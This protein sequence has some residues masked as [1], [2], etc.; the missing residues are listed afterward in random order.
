MSHFSPIKDPRVM[1]PTP[2]IFIKK[3]PRARD[4]APGVFVVKK[5]LY[6]WHGLSD[7]V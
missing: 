5:L 4:T 1:D 3:E 2:G 7:C 6:L